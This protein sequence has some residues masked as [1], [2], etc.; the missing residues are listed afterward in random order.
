MPRS[1]Q[2]IIERWRHAKSR[3]IPHED[4]WQE[5][6]DLGQP[7]RGDINDR[8]ARGERR[9]P[10]VFDA[11]FMREADGFSSFMKGLVA[12]SNEQWLVFD[13]PEDL[14]RQDV[15]RSRLLDLGAQR[16]LR[17][18][19]NSNFS[20]QLSLLLRDLTLLGNACMY[21]EEDD[22]V[23]RGPNGSTFGGILYEAVAMSRIWWVTG[24]GGRTIGVFRKFCLP[25]IEAVREFDDPGDAAVEAISAGEPTRRVNYLQYVYRNEGGMAGLTPGP[26]KPWLSTWLSLDSDDHRVVREA[27]YDYNPFVTAK[28]NPVDGEE[29][30][31]WKGHIAR[32]SAKGLNELKRQILIATGRDLNPVLHVEHDSAIQLDAGPN[33]IAVT[34]FGRSPPSYLKSETNY[35]IAF[36]VG[37]Q[38]QNDIRETL[39]ARERGERE[40]EPRSAEQTRVNQ[41]QAILNLAAPADVIHDQVMS[42]LVAVTATIM[43][44]AG[45]LPEFDQLAA[46]GTTEARPRIVSQ[47][48]T[49]QKE[50]A[51]AS[52]DAYVGKM[53]QIAQIIGDPSVLDILNMDT[54]ARRSAARANASAITRSEEELAQI[55]Q[56]RAQ[57]QQAEFELEAAERAAGVAGK[58]P[59]LIQSLAGGVV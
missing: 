18:L 44:E 58:A 5:I 49:A 34:R 54:Y 31:R 24:K 38:D 11:T 45:A 14:L 27:G 19:G 2:E 4:A 51:G 37:A 35:G 50:A 7:F 43:Q 39:H 56:A 46:R 21:I 47:F 13:T 16:I 12:P 3:R 26:R 15:E 25:A 1:A 23:A 57:R 32:A 20:I 9:I 48:F 36:E 6:N 8:K 28:V 22:P 10:A 41:V 29:Y 17:A 59:E 42:P 55:R 33:G 30:G 40:T 53:T 52:E